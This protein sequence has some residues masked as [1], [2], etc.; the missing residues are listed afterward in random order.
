MDSANATE[1]NESNVTSESC[2]DQ[3]DPDLEKKL[4]EGY[5]KLSGIPKLIL[6]EPSYTK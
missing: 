5:C 6:S 4:K 1:N 2:E 3:K